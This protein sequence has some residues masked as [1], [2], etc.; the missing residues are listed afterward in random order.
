MVQAV[1]IGDVWCTKCTLFSRQTT[2]S[3]V[4]KLDTLCFC[5]LASQCYAC[6]LLKKDTNQ[7]VRECALQGISTWKA[8]H[9]DVVLFQPWFPVLYLESCNVEI[10][11]FYSIRLG[12][13]G[14]REKN[15]VCI[16]WSGSSLAVQSNLSIDQAHRLRVTHAPRSAHHAP[17]VDLGVIS[18]TE[19][20]KGQR[21]PK[22]RQEDI[23]SPFHSFTVSSAL[24]VFKLDS[25]LKRIFHLYETPKH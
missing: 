7:F 12:L 15:Q 3:F 9:L 20:F 17:Q 4:P 8:I 25:F 22:A 2:N 5:E 16:F 21:C 10:D 19:P 13:L 1:E 23:V 24:F 11:N 14:Q 6:K 18:L